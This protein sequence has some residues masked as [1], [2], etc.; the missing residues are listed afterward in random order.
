[1]TDKLKPCPFCGNPNL[2]VDKGILENDELGNYFVCC[3]KCHVTGPA[4]YTAQEAVEAWNRRVN[5]E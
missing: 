4:G 5:A 2:L 1:M 3:N